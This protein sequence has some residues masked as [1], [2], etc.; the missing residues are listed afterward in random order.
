MSHTWDRPHHGKHPATQVNAMARWRRQ[1]S[2]RYSLLTLCD[3]KGI[4]QVEFCVEAPQRC[5]LLW[6]KKS[7]H[8]T[9]TSKQ[10]RTWYT[11]INAAVQTFLHTMGDMYAH[12][13][14][15]VEH[16]M[17]C[18]SSACGIYEGTSDKA[19]LELRGTKQVEHQGLTTSGA[20]SPISIPEQGRQ[21]FTE[22]CKANSITTRKTLT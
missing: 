16:R 5:W 14:C 4:S 10:R 22:F 12:D 20:A 15:I 3:S 7:K 8:D 9:K 2:R 19:E 13:E 6:G 17:P 21:E 11:E 1:N 18:S